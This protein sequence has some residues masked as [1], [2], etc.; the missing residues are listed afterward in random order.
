MAELEALLAATRRLRDADDLLH[1]V[2]RNG[3]E[4]AVTHNDTAEPRGSVVIL[5]FE[6]VD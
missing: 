1:S 2:F 3:L 6:T 4:N 5:E